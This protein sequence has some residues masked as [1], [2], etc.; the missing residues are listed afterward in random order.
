MVSQ[1]MLAA[2]SPIHLTE[3]EDKGSYSPGL[4]VSACLIKSQQLT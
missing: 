4:V 3:A 2:L 1:G